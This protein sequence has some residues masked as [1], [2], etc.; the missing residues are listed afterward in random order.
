MLRYIYP[1]K[2][3]VNHTIQPAEDDDSLEFEKYDRGYKFTVFLLGIISVLR[4][5]EYIPLFIGLRRYWKEMD[6]NG[7]NVCKNFLTWLMLSTP[8]WAIILSLPVIGLLL[9][10]SCGD[11]KVT[12]KV[13]IAYCIIN[14]FRY[15]WALSVRMGM[16][17]ATLKVK[18]IWEGIQDGN[19]TPLTY[20][21]A[22]KQVKKIAGIFETWFLFP[23]IIFFLISSLKAKNILSLWKEDAEEVEFLALVYFMLY[24]VNQMIFLIIPYL[25]AKKMNQYHHQCVMQ[26]LQIQADENYD[27]EPHLWGL[28]L[29][30]KMKS[31][32]YTL[33]LVMG[34]VFT[35]F[36][37]LV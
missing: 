28:G 12:A 22:G 29:K 31:F 19:A 2:V 34:L 4:I 23:W 13:F 3:C 17:Y 5:V 18:E 7:S 14:F 21:N 25:C 16:V 35:I 27:V 1:S 24:N 20:K 10:S 15:G 9:E 36:T 32:I 6:R 11:A 26:Q 30:V 8:A 33:F 37:P